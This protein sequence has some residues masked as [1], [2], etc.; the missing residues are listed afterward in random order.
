MAAWSSRMTGFLER[1]LLYPY[2]L[3]VALFKRMKRLSQRHIPYSELIEDDDVPRPYYAYCIYKA[4]LLAKSLG[5]RKISIIEFGVAGGNG[6]VN[7][8]Q[9]IGELTKEFEIEYEVYGFDSGQGLPDSGDYRDL[10]Y[11]WKPGFYQMDLQKLQDRLKISQLIIGDIRDT[12]PTFISKFKPSPIGC[13]LID[14]DYYTSTKNA[15]RIFDGPPEYYLPRIY[16]YCD[17]IHGTGLRAANEFTGELRAM[18]EFNEQNTTRKIA[19]ELGLRW[20]R[21]RPSRWNDQIFVY[22]DFAH[23]LYDSFVFYENQQ[24]PL[25]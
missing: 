17:D 14:L 25:E 24:S 16:C 8:E 18:N 22:H 13:I 6:L 21:N 5:Y 4:T 23:P 19:Q 10:K 9:H 20:L 12:S 1:L 15:L 3:R 11:V 2:P 7:I